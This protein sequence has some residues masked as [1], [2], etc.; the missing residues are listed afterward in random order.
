[1]AAKKPQNMA[2]EEAMAELEQIVSRLEQ[3]DLSLDQALKHF[4]RGVKLASVSQERLQQAE[5]KVAILQ[6]ND[7]EAPL[8][9]FDRQQEVN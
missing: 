1:M 3:G 9:P 2:F 5:Q 4:E 7:P 6:G 8:E